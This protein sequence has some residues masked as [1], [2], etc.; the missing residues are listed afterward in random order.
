MITVLLSLRCWRLP[1]LRRELYCSGLHFACKSTEV[2]EWIAT[3]TA[4]LLPLD[5]TDDYFGD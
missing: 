3:A 1:G 4:V 5:E 2:G